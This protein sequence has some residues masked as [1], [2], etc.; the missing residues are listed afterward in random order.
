MT[1]IWSSVLLLCAVAAWMA[2]AWRPSGPEGQRA[3]ANAAPVLTLVVNGEASVDVLPGTPLVFELTLKGERRGTVA[4]GNALRPWHNLIR[5]EDEH[6][7]PLPWPVSAH[8]EPNGISV[9]FSGAHPAISTERTAVAHLEWQRSEY[10]VAFAVDPHQTA[11]LSGTIHVRGV[12]ES[13]WWHWSSW[14][15]KVT[16]RGVAINVRSESGG[17]TLHLQRLLLSAKFFLDRREY[18]KANAA[19]EELARLAPD[20]AIAEI[21]RGDALVGLN[22]PARAMAA[23]RR[24]L[25]LGGRGYEEPVL[26]LD[27]IARAS[28]GRTSR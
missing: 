23:Y 6:G 17:S 2:F 10:T 3:A 21:L 24:A 27:R 20:R 1:R 12:L 19:S 5:L 26:L 14:R 13:P 4:V 15:G 18:D 22:Q 9:D 25:A 16:S 28:A 8:G 11:R 7:R